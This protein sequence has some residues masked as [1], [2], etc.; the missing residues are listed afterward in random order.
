MAQNRA[1]S[2]R[3][4][5]GCGEDHLGRGDPEPSVSKLMHPRTAGAHIVFATPPVQL[6]R[7]I[8]VVVVDVVRSCWFCGNAT[9]KVNPS[10]KINQTPMDFFF[11][12][13]SG[14]LGGRHSRSPFP[15]RVTGSKLS[16]DS[17]H[18][19]TL[20]KALDFFDYGCVYK[21]KRSIEN[22]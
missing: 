6:L 16:H 17:S 22:H 5:H 21:S 13:S 4:I 9:A 20:Q 12:S 18:A 10:P 3:H 19:R 14:V 2:P 15:Q 8:V 1:G 11:F 7:T